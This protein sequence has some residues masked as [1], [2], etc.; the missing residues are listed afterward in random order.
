MDDVLVRKLRP[1]GSEAWRYTGRVLRRDGN[2]IL[3][4]AFFNRDDL[5]FHGIFLARGDRFLEIYYSDRWYNIFEI[6]DRGDDHLKVWYCNVCLPAVITEDQIDC[7][8]L[9]LDLL[10]FPDGRQLILDEDEF[11]ALEIDPAIRVLAR[12]ALA[13]LQQRM[14]NLSGFSLEAAL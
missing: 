8:D 12:Q 7:V 5:P 3:I 10:V 14:S 9:A 1:G 2:S 13:D 4:E 6:H 11:A